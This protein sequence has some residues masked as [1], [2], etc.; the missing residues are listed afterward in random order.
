MAYSRLER[1]GFDPTIPNEARMI[2][3]FVGGKDNFAAD[4]EAA[5]HA[6]D[7]APE[8]PL[9][10]REGRRFLERAIRLLA[11][12]GIRQ[13]VDIG[14]G[15]PTQGNVH[16][17]AQAAVPDA[18]T[19]YVDNDP[20]V[21]VHARA[22]LEGDERTT[23]VE[24]DMREPDQVLSHPRLKSLINLDEPVAI[25]LLFAL[26]VIPDDELMTRIVRELRDAITPGSYVVISHSVSD[27]RP[28][29]T[30]K[31]AAMYQDDR[32]VTG[33]KRRDQ[34]RTKAEVEPLFDGLSLVDP[35][36]VYITH[37]R[38]LPGE[39]PASPEAVWSVGGVGRKD[40]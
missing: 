19:A 32:V 31:L 5:R 29:T 20:V 36:L 14:C 18:R 2:D 35:G 34:V 24:A 33:D 13:F 4:R 37:W 10:C 38:P 21:I 39:T 8:L 27:Q 23:V 16:E 22:I 25:L 17:V 1:L 40:A 7:I 28:E 26:D 30:A 3:Y 9:M 6:L 12:A 15:L 11:D